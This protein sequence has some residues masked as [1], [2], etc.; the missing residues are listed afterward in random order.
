[1]A[2]KLIS[3]NTQLRWIIYPLLEPILFWIVNPKTSSN[4]LLTTKSV[5]IGTRN[6]SWF[7][8]HQLINQNS[9]LLDNFSI[10]VKLEKRKLWLNRLS[11][12]TRVVLK[13]LDLWSIIIGTERTSLKGMLA[14]II[15][16]SFRVLWLIMPPFPLKY[17]NNRIIIMQRI[18]CR[19][20]LTHQGIFEQYLT[21][22]PTLRAL[23][24]H[25]TIR[26]TV[27]DF[28]VLMNFDQILPNEKTHF[29]QKEKKYQDQYP[30]DT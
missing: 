24:K 27:S 18:L 1:M 4:Q 5:L 2:I 17:Y 26:Q 23:L 30:R 8:F 9:K 25:Q 16:H 21:R 20:F 29:I 12:E 14:I 22:W 3:L 11:R 19:E 6:R 13:F 15:S 10:I 28:R 7:G